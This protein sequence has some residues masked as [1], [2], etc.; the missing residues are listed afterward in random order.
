M[1]SSI[2]GLKDERV[3]SKMSCEFFIAV[4][5]EK[6]RPKYSGHKCVVVI[7]SM[8]PLPPP[9]SLLFMFALVRLVQAQCVTSGYVLCLPA[10]SELGGVPEDDIDNPE[11]WDSIQSAIDDSAI[12]RRD[13]ASRQDALCCP[14]DDKC[15]MTESLVPFC[16][17]STRKA[18]FFFCSLSF[19]V[20]K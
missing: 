14:P 10:G 6:V 4:L 17:V 18:P 11:V 12:L 20:T 7:Y 13:L 3:P 9:L 16:Y 15:L 1:R 5:K 8:A 2:D 19:L